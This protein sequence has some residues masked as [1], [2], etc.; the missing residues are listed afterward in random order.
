MFKF[1]EVNEIRETREEREKRITK[2][3]NLSKL[4]REMKGELEMREEVL[5]QP[6]TKFNK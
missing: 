6:I 5:D 3:S 2:E 1:R 4:V